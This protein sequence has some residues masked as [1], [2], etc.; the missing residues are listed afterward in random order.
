MAL[1]VICA[2]ASFASWLAVMALA[3]AAW[4]PIRQEDTQYADK[5]FTPGLDQAI[6]RLGPL[7]WKVLYLTPPPASARKRVAVLRIAV[8]VQSFAFASF[9]ATLV[10]SFGH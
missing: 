5:L 1:T 10:S 3:A 7:S 8:A 6:Y 2:G 9:V 4:K